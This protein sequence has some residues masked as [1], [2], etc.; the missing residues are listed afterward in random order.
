MKKSQLRHLIRESLE[1]IGSSF[2]DPFEPITA[3]PELQKHIHYLQVKVH[4]APISS[5]AKERL[6]NHLEDI[7]DVL[8]R[9]TY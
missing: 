8:E 5:D 9:A 7:K 2:R 6:F 3:E 4:D 1:E